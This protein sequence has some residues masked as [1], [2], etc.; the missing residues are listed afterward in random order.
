MGRRSRLQPPEGKQTPPQAGE[1]LFRQNHVTKLIKTRRATR[2]EGGVSPPKDGAGSTAPTE[3]ASPDLGEG[4]RPSA[5]RWLRHP[6]GHWN[7][8]FI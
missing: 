6:D 7:T 5:T 1:C 8:N 2:P 3:Q 4:V